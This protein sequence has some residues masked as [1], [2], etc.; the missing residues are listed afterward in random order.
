MKISNVLK[1]AIGVL[2]SKGLDELLISR[3]E[4]YSKLQR[5]DLYTLGDMWTIELGYQ[6]SASI[7]S[8]ASV[9]S[10]DD[11]TGEARFVEGL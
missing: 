6:K 8:G 4:R 10:V 1:I 2:E 3:I 9:I 7:D 5:P 11:A